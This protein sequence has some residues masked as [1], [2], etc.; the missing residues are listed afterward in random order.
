MKATGD[1][2]SGTVVIAALLAFAGFM[3]AVTGALAVAIVARHRAG[4][5]ADLA[6]LA[7]ASGES[8]S[9]SGAGPDCSRAHWVTE[10]N[11]GQ[12]VDCRIL[13]DGSVQVEV[14]VRTP[15]RGPGRATGSARAAPG[16]VGEQLPRRGLTP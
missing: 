16:A 3:I 1:R 9:E 8:E 10:A 5:I 6:A 15:G 13:A 12:V 7:A 2:G 4:A 11:G 14:A